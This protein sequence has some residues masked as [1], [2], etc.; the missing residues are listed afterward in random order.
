ML[1]SKA[2]TLNGLRSSDKTNN[3]ICFNSMEASTIKKL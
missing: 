3:R 1:P 2:M